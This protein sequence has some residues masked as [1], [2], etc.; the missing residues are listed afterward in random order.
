[1]RRE[2]LHTWS[3]LWRHPD[4]PRAEIDSFRDRKLRAVVEHA[5]ARVP[6]YREKLDAAG[7]RPGDVRTATDLAALP[8]TTKRERRTRSPQDM[9]ARGVDPASLV[10]RYTAG[11]TG[12]P[13]RVL[14]SAL[15]D[16][17]LNQFRWRARALLGI[18][19]R[20]RIAYVVSP[21]VPTDRK[22]ARDRARRVGAAIGIY[23]GTTVD[24]LRSPDEIA[25]DLVSLRPDVISGYASSLVETIEPWLR[26]GG[27]RHPPRLVVCGGDAMTSSMRD[28]LRAG[29]GVPVYQT[30]GCHEINLVAWECR[31]T[32]DLHLCDDLAIVEVLHE[33]RPVRPGESGDVVVTNLHA[34]ASPYLRYELGD[35]AIAGDPICRCGAP[36]ATIRGV[37]GRT[38]D[39]LVLADGRVMHHWELIPMTFWDMPWHRQYQLVQES[40]DRFVLRLV[41]D[42]EPPA[43]D[44]EHVCS[45]AQRKLPPGSSFRVELI[46]EIERAR[47]GKWRVCLSRVERDA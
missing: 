31:E 13:V 25:R 6:F 16:H 7:V 43:G 30:Y 29:F 15:E 45:A 1:M 23:R 27:A 3:R 21:G 10:S 46:D 42:G 35:R 40:R 44:L 39:A 41:S 22:A 4:R 47:S 17:L 20:D 12:E 34:Y 26:H 24:C 5:L 9:V 14:R 19:V 11:S 8:F 37:Q 2:H 28:R 36:F 33:G 32:G 38:M 18:R